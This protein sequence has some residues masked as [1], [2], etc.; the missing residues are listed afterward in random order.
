MRPRS[1]HLTAR[2]GLTGGTHL[3]VTEP[4]SPTTGSRTPTSNAPGGFRKHGGR[5]G[6][7]TTRRPGKNDRT[8]E[9]RGAKTRQG[10]LR[11]KI[12]D[13]GGEAQEREAELPAPQ[14]LTDNTAITE[15]TSPPRQRAESK[16]T[17]KPAKGAKVVVQNTKDDTPTTPEASR[18]RMP[19]EGEHISTLTKECFKS[20]APL[21]LRGEGAGLVTEG[22]ISANK[23]TSIVTGHR[24]RPSPGDPLTAWSAPSKVVETVTDRGNPPESY[25][26]PSLGPPSMTTKAAGLATAI[27]LTV[28]ERNW[29]K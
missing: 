18:P 3:Q 8:H 22:N 19:A 11:A 16:P 26:Q 27:P 7:R 4:P 13:K 10:W 12:E 9:D 1:E 2:K 14:K 20:L 17:R 23:Q 6:C 21:L 28:K 5:S 25:T 29:R 15:H 24:D